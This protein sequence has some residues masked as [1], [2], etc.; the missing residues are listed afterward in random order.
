MLL[1]S[2]TLTSLGKQQV[3]DQAVTV[4]DNYHLDKSG[5]TGLSQTGPSQEEKGETEETQRH[6]IPKREPQLPIPTGGQAVP[7]YDPRWDPEDDKDEWSCN[8]FIHCILEGLR[9]TKVKSLNY[10]QV[11][12]VHQGPYRDLRML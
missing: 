3:L 1:L 6:W 2:Q 7:R 10:S 11:T 5:P 4:G 12:V 8:H 9:R